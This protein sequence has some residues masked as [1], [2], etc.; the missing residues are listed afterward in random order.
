VILRRDGRVGGSY[1]VAGREH[2]YGFQ[3]PERQ[4]ELRLDHASLPA[5]I[6]LGPSLTRLG[7]VQALEKGSG[8]W[9]VRPSRGAI[10]AGEHDLQHIGGAAA[11][12]GRPVVIGGRR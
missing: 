12:H 10:D 8:R 6:S 4:D 5:C 11:H 1:P 9:P 2:M 7:L 3:F